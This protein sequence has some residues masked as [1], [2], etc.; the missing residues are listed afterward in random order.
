MENAIMKRDRN[1]SRLYAFIA[2]L[3]ICFYLVTELAYDLWVR[4]ATSYGYFLIFALVI[5]SIFLRFFNSSKEEK[6]LVLYAAWFVVSRVL[7]GDMFLERE[8][9]FLIR[10]ILLS[11]CFICVGFIL[12]REDR[13]RFLNLVCALVCGYW[14]ILSVTGLYATVN[15]TRIQLPF[16]DMTVG[17]AVVSGNNQF[18]IDNMHRNVSGVWFALATVMMIYQFFSC[19]VKLWR[20]PITVAAIVFYIATAMSF[21]RAAQIG[22]CIAITMLFMLLVLDRLV[23]KSRRFRTLVVAVIIVIVLPLSYLGFSA[24]TGLCSALSSNP[25]EKQEEVLPDE[26]EKLLSSPQMASFEPKL[27]SAV[28]NEEKDDGE[29]TVI[30]GFSESRGRESL[31]ILSGRIPLWKAGIIVLREDSGRLL[32]GEMLD[33]YMVRVSEEAHKIYES[34]SMLGTNHM[35]NFIYDALMLTGL[36]GALILIVFTVFLLIRM[37]KVFFSTEKAVPLQLKLLTLPIAVL[38]LDNMMEACILRYAIM[39]SILFFVISGIF[40]AWSYEVLPGTKK[41]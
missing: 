18:T 14:F 38:L 35:H 25:A 28:E 22:L 11:E 31:T 27:L 4:L 24:A 40:L 37:I 3:L 33:R 7:N 10:T 15:F 2:L 9:Y 8:F 34:R 1:F 23:S 17:H 13:K 39:T 32:K 29:E 26:T 5:L 41:K 30:Q 19:K 6:C 20:I 36:P 21:C 12:D 16:T